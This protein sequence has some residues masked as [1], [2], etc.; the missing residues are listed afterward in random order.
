M[1]SE[2]QIGK[3]FIPEALFDKDNRF[4]DIRYDRGGAFIED[5]QSHLWLEFCERWLHLAG[6][7][8]LIDDI[9]EFFDTQYTI[10]YPMTYRWGDN[11]LPVVNGFVKANGLMQPFKKVDR[12]TKPFIKYTQPTDEFTKVKQVYL[13]RQVNGG[14]G[15]IYLC[16][17]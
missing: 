5:F 13:D 12:L 10:S 3:I 17:Y 7:A 6:Y 16:N 15:G 11:G 8:D 4:G 2:H 1:A 9:K 14:T